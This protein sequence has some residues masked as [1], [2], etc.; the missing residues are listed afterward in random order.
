MYET[1]QMFTILNALPL[2]TKQWFK[3]ATTA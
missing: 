3:H 1:F 2:L